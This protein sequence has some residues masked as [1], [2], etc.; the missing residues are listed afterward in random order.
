[1]CDQGHFYSW[2]SGLSNLYG[3]GYDGSIPKPS[4]VVAD[5]LSKRHSKIKK[6]TAINRFIILLLD[7][8]RLYC[9]GTNN[10]GVFGARSNPLVMSD[11]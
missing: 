2:G 3:W 1:M 10:G 9:F 11:L 7:N 8:G 6:F 5:L 4:K